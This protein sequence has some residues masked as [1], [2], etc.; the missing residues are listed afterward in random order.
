MFGA[1]IAKL[2]LGQN[3]PLAK[4]P[5]R[6][7]SSANLWTGEEW[8]DIIANHVQNWC[9]CGM[10][11]ECGNYNNKLTMRVKARD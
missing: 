5:H 8:N 9:Q 2:G 4:K 6:G 3:Q 11:M 7:Q 1:I 10:F